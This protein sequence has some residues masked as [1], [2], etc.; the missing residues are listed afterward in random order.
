[1]MDKELDIECLQ[2]RNHFFNDKI[3]P[4]ILL[5]LYIFMWNKRGGGEYMVFKLT[6]QVVCNETVLMVVPVK[7]M[8]VSWLERNTYYAGR[9]VCTLFLLWA[10]V[11]GDQKNSIGIGRH[12]PPPPPPPPQ[13]KNLINFYGRGLDNFY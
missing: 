7:V 9:G 1:M 13:K 4:N 3:V 2:V 8:R 12:Y 6:S 5:V 11:E 10:G